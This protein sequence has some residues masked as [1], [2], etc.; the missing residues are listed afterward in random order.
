ML[1]EECEESDAR[2]AVSDTNVVE[3]VPMLLTCPNSRLVE[4]RLPILE[5]FCCL[6]PGKA[7]V[8]CKVSKVRFLSSPF[9]EAAKDSLRQRCKVGAHGMFQWTPLSVTVPFPGSLAS[10]G[11]PDSGKDDAPL[12]LPPPFNPAKSPNPK[13]ISTAARLSRHPRRPGQLMYMYPTEWSTLEDVSDIMTRG[14][15]LTALDAMH[16]SR[17]V[18]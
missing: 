15:R 18:G 17:G 4:P 13:S 9:F 11:S 1:S 8:R 7:C 5:L 10:T 6:D 3:A 14:A 12:A 2:K 16:D